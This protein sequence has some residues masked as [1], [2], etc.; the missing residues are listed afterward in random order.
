MNNYCWKL[1]L[2]K[3]LQFVDIYGTDPELLGMVPAPGKI[4]FVFHRVFECLG[5]ELL[6]V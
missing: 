5:V 1:G 3:T 2:T 6:R 4:S